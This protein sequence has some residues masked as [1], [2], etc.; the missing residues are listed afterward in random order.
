MAL[1]SQLGLRVPS[2][3]TLLGYDLC[4]LNWAARQATGISHALLVVGAVVVRPVRCELLISHPSEQHGVRL[5]HLR[6]LRLRHLV[7]VE[8]E[9]NVPI[10][11]SRL[12][13]AGFG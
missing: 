7:V 10:I 3:L 11:S 9:S 4:L 6:S 12:L 2:A 8:L 1:S 5:G 13:S